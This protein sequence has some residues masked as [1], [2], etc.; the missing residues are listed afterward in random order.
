MRIGYAG[1][2]NES[3]LVYK[4]FDA[5]PTGGS[6]YFPLADT[7][8]NDNEEEEEHVAK[9]PSLPRLVLKAHAQFCCRSGAALISA[10]QALIEGVLGHIA[11][12]IRRRVGEINQRAVEVPWFSVECYPAR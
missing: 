2:A 9:I 4:V 5:A 7:C 1:R 10:F 3:A 11:L 12:P 8:V 6:R